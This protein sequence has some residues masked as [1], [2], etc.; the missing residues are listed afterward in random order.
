MGQLNPYEMIEKRLKE[1]YI[2]KEWLLNKLDMK[3]NTYNVYKTRKSFPI[4]VIIKA[5]KLLDMDLNDL[6]NMYL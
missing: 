3:L 5:F 1:I 2:N 4:D 6:K